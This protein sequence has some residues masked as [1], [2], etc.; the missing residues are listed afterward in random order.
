MGGGG[1]EEGRRW[2]FRV[3]DQIGWGGMVRGGEK[4][5]T[6]VLEAAQLPVFTSK[7]LQLHKNPRERKEAKYHLL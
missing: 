1:G 5:E 2:Q 4:W 3:E 7:S 6:K